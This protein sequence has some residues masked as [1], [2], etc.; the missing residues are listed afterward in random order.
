MAFKKIQPEQLQMPT[1]FSNL[2]DIV[3]GQQD[4]GIRLNLSRGQTGDY[5]FTGSLT[6][7]TGPVLALA[8]TSTNYYNPSPSGTFVLN[9][10]SNV[11][12]NCTDSI[13]LN[14]VSNTMEGTNHVSLNGSNQ[15]FGTDSNACTSI[16]SNGIFPLLTTGATILTDSTSRTVTAR[17]SDSLSMQFSG[18]AYIETVNSY[19]LNTTVSLNENS[20]GIF[21][22]GV[23]FF[24][25]VFRTGFSVATTH[26]VTGMLSGNF[27]ESCGQSMLWQ[28]G[29]QLVFRNASGVYTGITTQTIP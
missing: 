4:T 2:G 19:F 28:S 14:G 9:G 1:F 29:D 26:D 17:G 3:V 20:S 6:L 8:D 23:E 13:I 27:V 11:I 16:G 25:D 21:S 15:T 12:T 10:A 24:G 7:N 22:G 5:N 18:G